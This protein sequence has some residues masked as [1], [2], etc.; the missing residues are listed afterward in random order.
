MC[1]DEAKGHTLVLKCYSAGPGHLK[2]LQV[3]LG[4][5]D[6]IRN[7]L[8]YRHWLRRYNYKTGAGVGMA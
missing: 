7:S 3:V 4:L 8:M 1:E 5:H 2:G 6:A